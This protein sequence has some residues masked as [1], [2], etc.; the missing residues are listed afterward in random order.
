MEDTKVTVDEIKAMLSADLDVLAAEMAAA[1]NGAK[2]GRIIAESEEPVRDAHGKFRR[3]AYEKAIGLL[4]AKQE[5]LSPSAERVF[6]QG[7]QSGDA[8]DGQRSA[9]D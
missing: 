3:Q 1:I 8:P 4:Q 7:A 2:A 5:A 6:Q 9:D